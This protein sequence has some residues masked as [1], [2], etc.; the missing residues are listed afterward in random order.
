MTNWLTLEEVAQ[1]AKM[2]KSMLYDVAR[3]EEMPAH[4]M[5]RAWRFVA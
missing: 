2:G 4:K 5:G 3:K 1:Y